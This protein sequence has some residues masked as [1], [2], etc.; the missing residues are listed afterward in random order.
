M[1]IKCVPG[2]LVDLL[3]ECE[4][5]S[6]EHVLDVARDRQPWLGGRRG[7]VVEDGGHELADLG[8]GSASPAGGVGG[9]EASEHGGADA[10]R[11]RTSSTRTWT[12][13]RAFPVPA[14]AAASFLF[15]YCFVFYAR[16]PTWHPVIGIGGGDVLGTRL[17][18][19][20]PNLSLQVIQTSLSLFYIG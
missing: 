10:E 1:S 8:V 3:V 19:L 20:T 13:A 15:V 18:S 17:L 14:P 6:I 5:I 9:R 11:R 16:V 12:S 4:P 2:Q 7:V